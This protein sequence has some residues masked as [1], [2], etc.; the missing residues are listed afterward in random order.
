MS[1]VA[2][3]AGVPSPSRSGGGSDTP[4]MPTALSIEQIRERI[5]ARQH[6]DQAADTAALRFVRPLS[7]AAEA[8]ID[9]YQNPEG[10]YML[11]LPELD[12]MIRGI[13][14]GELCLI[15]GRAHSGKSAVALQSVVNNPQAKVLWYQWDESSLL[16]LAKLCAVVTNTNGETIEQRVRA[17]DPETIATIRKLAG[18]TFRNLVVIDEPL[19]FDEMSIALKEAETWWSSFHDNPQVDVVILDFLELLPGDQDATGVDA[20]VKGLKRWGKAHDVPL[21]CIHQANRAAGQRGKTIGMDSS[22]FGGDAEATF[23]LGVSRK[24]DDPDLDPLLYHQVEHTITVNVDKNKRAGGK[25]G[26]VDFHLD[27][28]TGRIS[29][30]E[31]QWAAPEPS[32]SWTSQQIF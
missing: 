32:A 19:G 1:L 11:G 21:I 15:V 14:R 5:A 24:R 6:D 31:D 20:K 10:R 27:P 13:G 12:V 29:P 25:R 9:V 26:A 2:P 28:D 18:Q 22:K 16:M 17:G 3:P 4:P 23:L 8:L 30:L 7:D